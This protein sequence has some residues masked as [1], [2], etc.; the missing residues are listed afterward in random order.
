MKLV[1]NAP[2]KTVQRQRDALCAVCVD[3]GTTN[4]RVWL[5]SGNEVL[6][7][8]SVSVGARDTA[9]DGSDRRIRNA[10][11]DLIEQVRPAEEEAS[12]IRPTCV[13]AA[14]MITSPLGLAEVPHVDAPAGKCEIAA[15][16]KQ[17]S[18]PDITELPVFLVPGVRSGSA[19]SDPKLIGELDVM[20]GEETLCVGLMT[21]GLLQAGGTLLNLGSHWKAIT[22]DYDGHVSSS[23]TSMSGELI[24][25][26]QSQTILASVLTQKWP[27][28]LNEEWTEA[29]MREQRR[30]GLSRALFCIRLLEQRNECTPDDRF[31]FLIGA[32]VASDLDSLVKRSLLTSDRPVVITGDR[33]VASAWNYALSEI[34]MRSTIISAD[35]LEQALIQG[36]TDIVQCMPATD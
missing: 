23:V 25:A 20:R 35:Q 10:L 1:R 19:H 9:R 17:Q 28:T 27:E 12:L 15:R 30:S 16:V 8:A 21:L 31:A 14:G 34:S 29:G 3:M 11:H 6:A 4:T 2:E 33:V 24:H 18:F 13:I 32:F 22:V 36:L 26:A 7:R 5:V